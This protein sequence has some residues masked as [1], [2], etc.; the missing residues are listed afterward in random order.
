[1]KDQKKTQCYSNQ[2]FF[3]C[4]FTV[5]FFMYLFVMVIKTCS[6]A[7]AGWLIYIK[8]YLRLNVS[9]KHNIDFFSYYDSKSGCANIFNVPVT[10]INVFICTYKPLI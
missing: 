6:L 10:V 1:M 2:P 3:S 7:I 5:D 4:T 9:S 8:F